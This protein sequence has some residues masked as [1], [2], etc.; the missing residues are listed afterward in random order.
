MVFK[1]SLFPGEVCAAKR[2]S[3]LVLGIKA[4]QQQDEDGSGDDVVEV[5]FTSE[6]GSVLVSCY[7][8]VSYTC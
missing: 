5:T 7:L 2:G 6:E 8:F 3:P 4:S 1:S